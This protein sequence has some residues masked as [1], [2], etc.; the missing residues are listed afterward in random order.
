MAMNMVGTPWKQVTRSFEMQASAG[1]G[2]K[3]G[4][5]SSV[6]PCVIVAVMASTI[7]KQWNMGT[8]SIMRSAVERSMR[9]PIHL[10]LFTM[11]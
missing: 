10:P 2:E 5:G 7:P 8:C 3:Y 6:P 9:S 4:S 1:F 11:L